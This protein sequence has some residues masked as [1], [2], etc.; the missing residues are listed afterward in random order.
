MLTTEMIPS[1]WLNRKIYEAT[2]VNFPSNSQEDTTCYIDIDAILKKTQINTKSSTKKHQLHPDSKFNEAKRLLNE[3]AQTMAKESADVFHDRIEQLIIIKNMWEQNIQF[4]IT[5]VSTNKDL[6]E[7]EQ[8]IYVPLQEEESSPSLS[9]ESSTSSQQTDSQ[10]NS[11]IPLSQPESTDLNFVDLNGKSFVKDIPCRGAPT[12]AKRKQ[13]QA[14]LVVEKMKI[15]EKE[16]PTIA[17]CLHLL[18]IKPNDEFIE[19][20]LRKETFIEED[21]L[22][23][24]HN[25]IDKSIIQHL[26][27]L[28]SLSI[29]L[30][31]YFTTD[32]KILLNITLENIEK[33][34]P[35]CL[36]CSL[37]I[38]N[39]S[40]IDCNKC[41]SSF[42]PKCVN[43]QYVPKKKAWFCS[44]ECRNT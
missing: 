17:A 43:V 31:K 12:K 2:E 7:V 3:I 19:N 39:D 24:D 15:I 21:Q 29:Q 34:K 37:E 18:L 28:D 10:F 1:R 9:Q 25:T 22:I 11:Q 6:N 13:K 5:P 40:R 35:N 42:H 8:S 20:V 41:K 30:S 38:I 27:K 36:K 32:A 16:T 23:V 4:N 33:L 44:E 26:K 14:K